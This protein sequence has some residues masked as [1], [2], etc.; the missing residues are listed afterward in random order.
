[1]TKFSKKDTNERRASMNEE[2]ED[3]VPEETKE[4]TKENS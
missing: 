4:E 2:P 3:P 1:M